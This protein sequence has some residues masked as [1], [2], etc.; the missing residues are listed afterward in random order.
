MNY[1]SPEGDRFL[2]IN[3][4]PQ[5]QAQAD[6]QADILEDISAS[7]TDTGDIHLSYNGQHMIILENPDLPAFTAQ[8]SDDL[9]GIQFEFA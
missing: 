7:L 3:N 4:R 9:F 8:S 6:S 2:I 5:E 1:S